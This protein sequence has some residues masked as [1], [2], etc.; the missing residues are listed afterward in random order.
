MSKV[1]QN[2]EQAGSRWLRVGLL[3]LTLLGPVVKTIAER[4]RQRSQALQDSTLTAQMAARQ[5]LDELTQASRQVALEQAQ[6][7][8]EQARQLQA[9]AL[10][11]RAALS[12]NTEQSLKVAEQ[13]RKAGEEWSRELMKRGSKVTRDLAERGGHLTD[14]LVERGGKISADLAKRSSKMARDL[15]ERS[16]DLL[17]PVRKSDGAFWT[18]LG[19]SVGLTAA[20]VVTYLFVRQRIL[21]QA[22][23]ENQ[24]IELPQNGYRSP[25]ERET[26]A[27][28]AAT[29]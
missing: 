12:E 18:A 29:E 22:T 3:A 14:E 4:L 1:N 8:Q 16:E 15:A 20:V 10:Q 9:Q 21:Q 25:T 5:R 13:M 11:L 7:L 26:P 28:P 24:Q 17:E 27:R 6:Q 23:E 2:E 19:F